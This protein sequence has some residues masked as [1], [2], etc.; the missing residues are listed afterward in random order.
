MAGL[1]RPLNSENVW[2]GATLR[3]GIA[4]VVYCWAGPGK[5]GWEPWRTGK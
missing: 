1:E 4:R 5:A 2:A 3:A